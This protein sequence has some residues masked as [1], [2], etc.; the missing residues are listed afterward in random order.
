MG[1][2][3]STA[4]GST[5]K[6]ALFKVFFMR[7]K[8]QQKA[9]TSVP[10]SAWALRPCT[11]AKRGRTTTLLAGIRAGRATSITFPAACLACAQWS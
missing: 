11:P 6:R 10:A 9:L 3:D 7:G 8:H 5:A 4:K 2:A 1:S